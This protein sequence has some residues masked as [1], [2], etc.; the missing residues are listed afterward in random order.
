MIPAEE[1]DLDSIEDLLREEEQAAAEAEPQRNLV[2]LPVPYPVPIMVPRM[3]SDSEPEEELCDHDEAADQESSDEGEI[4]LVANLPTLMNRAPAPENEVNENAELEAKAD[5][6]PGSMPQAN[7]EGMNSNNN[8]EESR[9]RAPPRLPLLGLGDEQ[10]APNIFRN[11]ANNNY[12]DADTFMDYLDIVDGIGGFNNQNF[13]NNDYNE[14]FP[15]Y[16]GAEELVISEPEAMPNSLVEESEGVR[17]FEAY[18]NETEQVIQK[19]LDEINE[20]EKDQT[21]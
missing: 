10:L 21:K 17:P 5:Q 19:L 7:P 6:E 3:D 16:Y 12:P 9:P 14:Y 1:D 20:R 13:L 8:N 18:I 4:T 2:G 11:L 15:Q